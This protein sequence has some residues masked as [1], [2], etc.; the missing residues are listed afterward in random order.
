VGEVRRPDKIFAAGGSAG[1][2]LMGA[3]ANMAGE[4]YR[5]IAAHV[6]YVD[7]VTSMLD[8][9]IPLVTNELDEWAHPAKKE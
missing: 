5:G 3:V 9:S 4:K 7:V 8:E 2:L 1:G 6:P